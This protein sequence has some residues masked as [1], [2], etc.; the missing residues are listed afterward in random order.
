MNNIIK[1]ESLL[2]SISN[3]SVLIKP[4]EGSSVFNFSMLPNNF[5]PEQSQR[6]CEVKIED[7]FPDEDHFADNNSM[8]DKII[9][10]EEKEC[11]MI[12]LLPQPVMPQFLFN[13]GYNEKTWRIT[14]QKGVSEDE[15]SHQE[16]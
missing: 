5:E 14:Q 12:P 8:L 11:S 2:S 9:K 1:E 15:A 4:N 13:H 6:V 10:K 3:I 16:E 7:I